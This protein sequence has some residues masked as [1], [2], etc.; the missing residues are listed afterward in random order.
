[1]KNKALLVFMC[2]VYSISGFSQGE[3]LNEEFTNWLPEGWTTIDGPGSAYYSHW[4]HNDDNCATVYV[5]GDNQD[6]WLIT[7]E[8]TL[9]SSGELR[10]SACFKG[11]FYRMVTI[12]EGDF[13]VDISTDGGNNWETIWKEDDQTMVEASTVPWPWENNEWLYPSINISAY[14]G[15]DITVAF[16][17]VAPTGDADWWNIDDVVINALVQDD[18]ELQ[19]FDFPEY[20][21][22][23]NSETFKGTFKNLGINDITSFEVVYTVNGVE[24]PPCLI[25][26]LAVAYNTTYDFEHNIPYSFGDAQIYDLELTITVVNGN[27]DSNPANNTL[28]HDISIASEII[29][30][31]PLFEVFTSSTCGTCPYANETVD[32]VLQNNPGAYS[33]VKYQVYWPGDGDPYYIVDD[34]VRSVYYGVGGVPDLYANGNYTDGFSFSQST[35]T[36]ASEQ[37]AFASID[38]SYFYDGANITVNVSVIPKI[39]IL[40]ASLHM[41]V[42]EKTTYDNVGSNGET[43]FHNVVMAMLPDGDGIHTDLSIDTPVTVSE[44]TNLA[45]TFIEEFDDLQVVVWVQ[46]NE[47]KYVIQSECSDLVVGI[48]KMDEQHICVYPNPATNSLSVDNAEGCDIII[49]D[50]SGKIIYGFTSQEV[51]QTQD[52]SNLSKGIYLIQIRKNNSLLTSEKLIITD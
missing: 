21:E 37:G 25:E 14:A 39:N 7:P 32:A 46:D 31:K 18:I 34:S 40:N 38:L 28:T 48:D 51:S 16:R 12:D 23:G 29:N 26:G 10:L 44:S 20:G 3:F 17:Y 13:Y 52:I 35:F 27:E 49:T 24:S 1:M 22:I 43:E 30:R 45:N 33:L 50:I 2:F 9:P 8:V 6:E 15:E 42:V 19:I 36:T 4:F 47:T 5:T 41:A 11:S